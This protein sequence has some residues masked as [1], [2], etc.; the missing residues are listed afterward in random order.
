MCFSNIVGAVNIRAV[1]HVWEMRTA[2]SCRCVLWSEMHRDHILEYEVP[3]TLV[4]KFDDRVHRA[5]CDIYEA[6][7]RFVLV[8]E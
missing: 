4:V 3:G 5:V 2:M 8:G 1:T 6:D 7:V